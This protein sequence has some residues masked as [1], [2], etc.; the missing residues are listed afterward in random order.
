[1][2][3]IGFVLR[4]EMEDCYIPHTKKN[5]FPTNILWQ[6]AQALLEI[7]LLLAKNIMNCYHKA[8]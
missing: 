8:M 7:S 1:M 6:A 5:L 3:N 4:C 2:Q